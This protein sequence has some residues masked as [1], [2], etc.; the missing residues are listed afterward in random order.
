MPKAGIGGVTIETSAPEQI[1][2]ALMYE[3]YVAKA[4][5]DGV[6]MER[7]MDEAYERTKNNFEMWMDA[8]SLQRQ[9]ELSHVYEWGRVGDPGGR[10]FRLHRRKG[11]T[12]SFQITYNF[13]NSR[14]VVPIHPRLREPGPTGKF[15][16]KSSIF[17]RKAD[18]MEQG[19][20]VVIRPRGD[21]Y[22]AIPVKNAEFRGYINGRHTDSSG[23]GIA[24]SRGPIR[25]RQPGGPLARDGFGRNYRNYFNSGTALKQL[26]A[27][28]TLERPA[29]TAKIAGENLPTEIRHMGFKHGSMNMTAIKAYAEK[30]VAAAVNLAI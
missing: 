29:R 2:G 24:F 22:L 21:N 27:S 10:L 12:N 6:G 11:S 5:L 25:V 1:I 19:L 8:K 23:Y 4:T 9:R 18:V 20:P 30:A 17:R 15:V 3:F 14:R 16:K 7:F 26:K 13:I 28:G